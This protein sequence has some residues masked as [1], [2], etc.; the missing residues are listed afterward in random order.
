MLKPYKHTDRDP[1]HKCIR[2][3]RPLKRNLLA[4]RPKAE[5]CY[6][7]FRRLQ[8]KIASRRDGSSVDFC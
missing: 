3:G 5:L 6:Q 7:D 8:G 2:C 1:N 4:K